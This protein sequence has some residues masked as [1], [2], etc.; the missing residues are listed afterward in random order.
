MDEVHV[1][2]MP[3]CCTPGTLSSGISCQMMKAVRPAGSTQ[4][5]MIL[6]GQGITLMDTP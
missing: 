5:V 3:I 4:I 6:F 2:L 1:L